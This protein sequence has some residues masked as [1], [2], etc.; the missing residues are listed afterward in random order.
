[1][2]KKALVIGINNYDGLTPGG[3]IGELEN[4][5]QD[6]ITIAAL[7]DR[8]HSKDDNFAVKKIFVDRHNDYDE[9]TIQ[10]VDEFTTAEFYHEINW[11]FSGHYESVVLYFAGHGYRDALTQND[12]LI[13]TDGTYPNYGVQL[14]YVLNKANNAFPNIHNCTIILDCCHS[15]AIGEERLLGQ[16]I[17]VVGRGV[18]ILAACQ[19]SQLAGDGAIGTNGVFTGMLRDGL[20]GQAGDI[21]GRVTP[22]S[23]YNLVD[24][25]LSPLEQRPVYKAN[26][27]SFVSLRQAK[28]RIKKNEVR[29]LIGLF[30]NHDDNYPLGPEHEREVDRGNFAEDYKDIPCDKEKFKTYR[31]LQAAFRLSLIEPTVPDSKPELWDEKSENA[32]WPPPPDGSFSMWHAAMYQTGCQ[33]TDYGKRYWDLVQNDQL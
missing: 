21:F 30:E 24:Q 29:H 22:A 18:T 15:G 33:L 9:K 12:Y 5:V 14:D 7:L 19:A 25:R 23:L 2:A 6:A 1:M 10:P 28:E 11:L 8:H 26:I 13:T 32:A 16:N 17:S 20:L 27:S 3:E 4:A 31:K